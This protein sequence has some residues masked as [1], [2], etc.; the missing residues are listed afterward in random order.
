[1]FEFHGWAVLVRG[2][3]G[4]GYESLLAE[5]KAKSE[6]IC[7]YPEHFQI[8]DAGNEMKVLIAHGLR[9]HFRYQII[10]LF[11]CIAGLSSESY[12]LLYVHDD[13][14]SN[15]DNE[16]RVWRL[17]RGRLEERS[18]PFLSPYVPTIEE[19]YGS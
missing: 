7:E 2:E 3:A 5:V 8:A 13:E 15:Y 12:G 4:T 10:E 14:N 19:P 17:A 11:E 6:E 9:N 16:F 1:L 18:D